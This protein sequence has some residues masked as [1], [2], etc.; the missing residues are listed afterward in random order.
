MHVY[1]R[2]PER[3][4]VRVNVAAAKLRGWWIPWIWSLRW[5]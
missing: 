5:L 1:A 4:Y 3:G 2:V